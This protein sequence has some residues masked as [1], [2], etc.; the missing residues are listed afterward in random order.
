MSDVQTARSLRLHDA[1]A[2]NGCEAP[3]MRTAEMKRTA[4]HDFQE[5]GR[6]LAL[7]LLDCIAFWA[8]LVLALV[9]WFRI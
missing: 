2:A 3:A 1:R 5:A 4:S 7:L 6:I 9:S 8:V